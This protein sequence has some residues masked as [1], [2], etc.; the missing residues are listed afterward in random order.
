[1]QGGGGGRHPFFDFGDPFGGFGPP[2]NLM[3]SFFGGR[4]P[5]DDPFFTHPFGGM[6][7]SSFFGPNG[8]LHQCTP[9]GFLQHQAPEPQQSR[10]PIIEEL[11]SDDD[12]EKED[13][14]KEKNANPRK[15]DRSS[16]EP[17]V[18]DPDDEVEEK[19]S[20]Y[21]QYRNDYSR[22]NQGQSQPQAH[23]FTF[24]SSSVTYGGANGAYYTSS[25]T[26]RTGSDGLTFDESKEADA[27][28]GQAAHRVSRGLH[29]KG[30]SLIRELHSDGNVDT[31]QTLHNLNED[32]LGGFEEAWKGN[33]QKH[34]P[35]LSR[36]LNVNGGFGASGSGQN[37][38]AGR[39]GW[40]LPSSTES[41]E[42]LGRMPDA[43][44]RGVSSQAEAQP[45][46]G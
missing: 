17:L 2:R 19:K 7:E 3:S 46:R 44:D 40:A 24:Q 10:G 38:H 41:Q 18:E 8:I 25:R 4:D 26:R 35:G 22:S 34:L 15:H 42:N 23:N 20:K 29:N 45:W 32:E 30:H 13:T 37:R 36:D 14:S 16:N 9:S 39:G 33:A 11:N 12:D 5:F 27:T 43:G 31:M 28:T 1:M 6:F 21:L